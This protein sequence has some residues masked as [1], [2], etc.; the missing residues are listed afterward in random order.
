MKR[1]T[2]LGRSISKKQRLRRRS[3]SLVALALRV[4]L[5]YRQFVRYG[6]CCSDGLSALVN[7]F[8]NARNII[9]RI[10]VI[11]RYGRKSEIIRETD[12]ANRVFEVVSGTVCTYKM[13]R[14]GRRQ[15]GG[16]YFSGDV[17]G[18]EAVKHNLAAQA[19]TDAKVRVVKKQTL[20]VLAS[21][22]VKVAHQ[23]LSV[24]TRELERKQEL[25]LLLSRSAR[26]RVIGFLRDMV[27]RASAN[28]DRIALPMT[29]QD[30]ADY[31]ALTIETVSRVFWDL[32]RRGAI[33]IP[34]YR[35]IVLR[36]RSANEKAEAKRVLS[37]FEGV[38]GRRPKTEQEL[39]CWLASSEG[40][41]ATLFE[42]MAA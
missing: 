38:K 41:A 7:G 16:F 40:K 29:R 13:L 42:L 9:Q 30:I 1:R 21:S 26:E 36:N 22:D 34:N 33:A 12:S 6:A 3:T 28:E 20:N 14:D 27:E 4:V 2:A 37:L 25:V 23:L 19:I 31:L 11:K 32:E 5:H 35:S 10:G 8:G 17:F 39:D 24:M 18:L 15:I